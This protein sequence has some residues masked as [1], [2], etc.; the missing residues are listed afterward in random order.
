MVIV[1]MT[2][3]TKTTKGEIGEDLEKIIGL[4]VVRLDLHHWEVGFWECSKTGSSC[5]NKFWVEQEGRRLKNLLER[6]RG[7]ERERE[8]DA[9]WTQKDKGWLPSTVFDIWDPE[10]TLKTWDLL[11]GGKAKSS[12]Q[13]VV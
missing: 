1:G 10:W 13:P 4:P 8:A 3:N 9:T 2:I 6:E 7:G 5:C 12:E 11:E